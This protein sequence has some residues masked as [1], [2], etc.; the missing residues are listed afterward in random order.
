[1]SSGS[2]Q[3]A[4]QRGIQSQ[5]SSLWRTGTQSCQLPSWCRSVWGPKPSSP[6]A[7]PH[8]SVSFRVSM[9]A[10]RRSSVSTIQGRPS[11]SHQASCSLGTAL[12]NL[13]Q[14][15]PHPPLFLSNSCIT[16]TQAAWTADGCDQ[17]RGPR[18]SSGQSIPQNSLVPFS[19]WAAFNLPLTPTGPSSPGKETGQ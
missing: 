16:S 2:R 1:M 18:E 13:H 11:R 17:A 19:L 10:A 6:R 5:S 12:G 7:P 8:H 15:P 14:P 4:S 9:P 3:L